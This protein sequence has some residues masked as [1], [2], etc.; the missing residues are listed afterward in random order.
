M[1]FVN[2]FDRRVPVVVTTRDVPAH[3]KLSRADLTTARV[4]VDA[5]VPTIP[6]RQIAQVVGQRAVA[7]L[8]KGS[9]LMTS[10]ISGAPYPP[11]GQ[12][13]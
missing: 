5:S 12:A 13:L 4:A 11:P 9:L 6:E 1:Y 8:R 2:S 7:K 10:E 3:Q